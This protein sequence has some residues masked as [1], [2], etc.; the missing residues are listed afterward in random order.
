MCQIEKPSQCAGVFLFL[1]LIHFLKSKFSPWAEAI[2]KPQRA[3]D[4]KVLLAKADRQ[5]ALNQRN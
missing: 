1:Q 3:K 4:L 5:T 2:K